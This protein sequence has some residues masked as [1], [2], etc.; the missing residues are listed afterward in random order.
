MTDGQNISIQ[1][2]EM[3][4]VTTFFFFFLFPSQE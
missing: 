2:T 1:L 4:E 3:E